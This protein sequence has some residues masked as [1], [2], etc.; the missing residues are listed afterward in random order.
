[1]TALTALDL[2]NLRNRPH[3]VEWWLAVAPYGEPVFTARVNDPAIDRGA[4]TIP[5]DGGVGTWS[6]VKPGMTLWV[7]H[8]GSVSGLLEV[9][10][11]RIRAMTTGSF[12]VAENDDILWEDNLVLTVPGEAGFREL[13]GVYPR[14]VEGA[15]VTFYKDYD[16]AYVNEGTHL[17]PKANAGPPCVA[18]L[19]TTGAFVKWIGEDSWASEEA[20]AIA[21]QLWTFPDATPSSSGVLGTR[22]APV[23]CRWTTTGFRYVELRVV[24]GLGT[25]GTVHVP[26]WIFGGT[27][28]PFY[29]LE[30]T[31]FQGDVDSGWKVGL[32]VFEANE[33]DFPDQSLVVLGATVRYGNTT[34]N[35]GGFPHRE[36]VVF[37]GWLDRETLSFD[38]TTETVEFEAVSSDEVMGHLPSFAFSLEQATAPTLWTEINTLSVDRAMH[39]LLEFHST[40]NQ[41]LHVNRVGEVPHRLV[42]SPQVF[43]KGSI[44][45][46]LTND[47]L[48]DAACQAMSDKQGI[49]WERLN[50]QMLEAGADRNAVVVTC[51]LEARDFQDTSSISKPHPPSVGYVQGGGFYLT[52]PYLSQ[53]PGAAPLQNFGEDKLGELIVR[54]Q[55]EL[56]LWTGLRLAEANNPFANVDREL[57]GFWTGLDPAWGEWIQITDTDPFE[58]IE[59]NSRRFVLSSM[60]FRTTAASKAVTTE[61][62][63]SMESWGPPGE[64]VPV[65]PPPTPDEPYAPPHPLTPPIEP[66]AGDVRR[67][68]VWTQN[69][70][71]YTDDMLRHYVKAVA[72]AGTVG[73]TLADL[74]AD[75]GASGVEA[76]DTVYNPGTGTYTTVVSVDSDQQITMAA[77]IGLTD[78]KPYFITGIQWSDIL[79]SIPGADILIQFRHIQTGATTVG[80]WMLTNNGVYYAANVLTAAPSWSLRLELTTVQAHDPNLVDAEFRGIAVHSMKPGFAIVL[81]S[82]GTHNS[83]FGAVYTN[84]Y[85]GLWSYSTFPGAPGT[86]VSERPFF[87]IDIDQNS[88]LIGTV[89]RWSS[90]AH[91]AYLYISGNG[92]AT[93]SR[94]NGEMADWVWADT[95]YGCILRTTI[96]AAL[97]V[98]VGVFDPVQSSGNQGASW[99]LITPAGY[100]DDIRGINGFF[101]DATDITIC[102]EK[103]ASTH[104]IALRSVDGGGGWNEIG[105]GNIH[106]GA[107]PGGW[108]TT[109]AAAPVVWFAD[110]NELGW[111]ASIAASTN[112]T[113]ILYSDDG[114]V[115]WCGMMGNWYAIFATFTGASGTSGATGNSDIDFLPRVEGDDL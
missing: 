104:T 61:V 69:E 9:G 20:T 71:A 65:P 25:T 38:A 35:V 93:F 59:W 45:K 86:T 64:T 8:T 16:R 44:W 68:I 46:Q 97:R 88:G 109:T 111:V 7:G 13:W 112:K 70:L 94:T 77:D 67:A 29:R 18:W 66:L 26:T 19:G 114:G 96:Q 55:T 28:Q 74:L 14:L 6:D 32:K 42:P 11:V 79:G 2:H 50:P 53:A 12:L 52:T 73:V 48:D 107:R 23:E 21:D 84:D 87:N 24:D 108:S 47:L 115:L 100:E 39:H 95:R 85:G 34:T 51:G 31:S 10:T 80:G 43:S 78:G 98:N 75:Y 110:R 113:R 83:G 22:A 102:L 92:G 27:T 37:M 54:D 17:P 36:N 60:G 99:S 58:R 90:I 5:F 76:G 4:M 3:E 103:T 40:V 91:R 57:V 62:G 49:L 89:G 101:D 105:D 106:F 41:V 82:H 81:F 1:M 72:T 33:D 30:I 56:N 15:P 63:L